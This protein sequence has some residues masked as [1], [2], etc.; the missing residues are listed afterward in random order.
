M[1]LREAK[2]NIKEEGYMCFKT[3]S[4]LFN[5]CHLLACTKTTEVLILELLFADDYSLLAHTEETLLCIVNSFSEL[6]KAF[7]L[8]ISL[9][10]AE[11]MY[12]KPP[13]A[14]YNP[15]VISIDGHKFNTVEQFTYL[16]SA[17]SNDATMDK[18]IDNH[19]AKVHSSFGHLEKH[20]WKKSLIVPG[21]KVYRAMVLTAL[22]YGL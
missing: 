5:L 17:I 11:V 22:L 14:N 1:M 19:L 18:D 2:E 7:D 3:D 15:P 20:V 4:S 12:Q 8:T 16:G 13:H 21:N 9:K 6:A 10:K